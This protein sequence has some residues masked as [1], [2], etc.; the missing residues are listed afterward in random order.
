MHT[1][2]FGFKDTI[3]EAVI[4]RLNSRADYLLI[5]S[6]KNAIDELVSKIAKG[7]YDLVLGLGQYSG[8]DVSDIRIETNATSQF[9][10]DKSHFEA[11]AIPYAF[12]PQE[13]FKLANNIGNSWCNLVSYRLIKTTPSLRY[14][15]L[16][17]PRTFNPG[18]AAEAIDAQLN[19][20]KGIS[21][22]N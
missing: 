21:L 10:N 6:N 12:E 16:H 19:R 22:T 7:T 11:I 18:S 17:I 13:H 3:G 15:F 9:R 1:L 4:A 2:V 5:D 20:L 8:V 14:T